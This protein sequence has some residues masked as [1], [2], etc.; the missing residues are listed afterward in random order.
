MRKLNPEIAVGFLVASLFWIGVLGWQWQS[1]PYQSNPAGQKPAQHSD[2]PEQNER[3]GISA[4]NGADAG[5]HHEQQE[6]KSEFWSAKLSD[7]ALVVFTGLLV[8]FTYRLWKSTDKL[9]A[10][11]ERQI[12]AAERSASVAERA[13][14]DIERPYLFVFNVGRLTIQDFYDL[15]EDEVGYNLKVTYEVA[16]HGKIPAIIESLRANLSVF[17]DP[18]D[19]LAADF[20]HPL[21]VAPVLAAGEKRA[22]VPVDIGWADMETDEY[23]N[24][25]PNFGQHTLFLRVVINYRGPFTRGHETSIA[26]RYDERTHRFVEFLTGEKYN[27]QT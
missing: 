20:D 1:S 22:D 9:W 10:A 16:N 13:L 17:T 19:P 11:G 7:W 14:A 25:V 24:V 4:I 8:L 18:L 3:A 23:G 2:P 27:H 26:L 12:G 15:E 5:Q 21:V 6:T